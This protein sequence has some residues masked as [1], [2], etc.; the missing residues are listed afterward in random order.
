MDQSPSFWRTFFFRDR[1]IAQQSVTS[2][3]EVRVNISYWCPQCNT[4]WARIFHN[5][6]EHTFPRW[7]LIARYCDLHMHQM[8]ADAV[9]GCFFDVHRYP[10]VYHNVPRA[11]LQHDFLMHM[12]YRE[13]LSAKLKP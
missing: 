13:Q 11:V 4:E 9:A 5:D 12:L 10:S 1:H 3:E 2:G 8:W 7:S 6:S